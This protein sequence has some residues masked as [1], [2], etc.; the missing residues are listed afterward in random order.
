[1]CNAITEYVIRA[2]VTTEEDYARI[3]YRENLSW[4]LKHRRIDLLRLM[5]KG[6]EELLKCLLVAM[7]DNNIP[8]LDDWVCKFDPIP[9]IRD[10]MI[11]KDLENLQ[12]LCL[13]LCEILSKC[14]RRTRTCLHKMF[15]DPRIVK[16]IHERAFLSQ[17]DLSVTFFDMLLNLSR[18][19]MLSQN[20]RIIVDVENEKENLMMDTS[21]LSSTSVSACASSIRPKCLYPSGVACGRS[22]TTVADVESTS[23][24][25]SPLW[26]SLPS[27]HHHH[28]RKYNRVDTEPSSNNLRS[29][30]TDLD[31]NDDKVKTM[32]SNQDE[33]LLLGIKRTRSLPSLQGTTIKSKDLTQPILHRRMKSARLKS[34][35]QVRISARKSKKHRSFAAE[36]K[37]DTF[38]V[39]NENALLTLGIPLVSFFAL[40]PFMSNSSKM[41]IVLRRLDR[42]LESD[43]RNCRLLCD[44]NVA[45]KFLHMLPFVSDSL[46]SVLLSIITRLLM[47]DV[48]ASQAKLIFRLAQ[49][50]RFADRDSDDDRKHQRTHHP[51]FASESSMLSSSS[52][53]SSSNTVSELQMLLLFLIG[54]LVERVA[55][56]RYFHLR[57]P[58][59]CMRFPIVKFPSA[60]VGYTLSFRICVSKEMRF[61]KSKDPI[62]ILALERRDGSVTLRLCFIT[63]SSKEKSLTLC[64]QRSSRPGGRSGW[65]NRKDNKTKTQKNIQTACISFESIEWRPGCSWCTVTMTHVN[66]TVH[67]FADGKALCHT[68][69]GAK[70]SAIDFPRSVATGSIGGNGFVGCLGPINLFR[71]IPRDHKAIQ[72][73]HLASSCS[74]DQPL[75][76]ICLISP[77]GKNVCAR[78]MYVVT[79][80]RFDF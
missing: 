52:S 64:V 62:N 25:E 32:I 80:E 77:H 67:L 57:T 70:N 76:R 45:S 63:S 7:R 79:L 46:Q 30:S 65:Y 37:M 22:F 51:S 26:T 3:A 34:P 53:S 47:Y 6:L 24:S 56:T 54:Q 78:E 33:E 20:P 59:A 16:L 21:W 42:L 15:S 73:L 8:R 60:K 29:T 61:D 74:V 19:S 39:R 35:T 4:A 50:D 55:P 38:S 49:V 11:C 31:D 18:V 40:L 27:V 2:D 44:A 36:Q 23:P 75:S 14:G 71:G 10:V 68:D 69:L 28:R 5:F 48:T 13:D 58:D 66:S 12:T 1:M 72:Q 43:P 17:I 9:V 41:R